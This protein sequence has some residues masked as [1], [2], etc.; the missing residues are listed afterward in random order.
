MT[1][2][3]KRGDHELAFDI[4][5]KPKAHK[6]KE[7]NMGY[8]KHTIRGVEIFTD[9]SDEELMAAAEQ[10]AKG[11]NLDDLD[12]EDIWSKH[13][14]EVRDSFVK[15]AEMQNRPETAER[16]PSETKAEHTM[17]MRASEAVRKNLVQET[18]RILFAGKLV[19]SPNEKF[20]GLVNTP[21]PKGSEVR[22]KL[23]AIEA[24]EQEV[25]DKKTEAREAEKEQRKR[26]GL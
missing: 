3:K 2:E 4:D 22:D 18:A 5:I 23:D 13:S 7:R 16:L 11:E 6:R 14:K 17:R 8:G 21:A 9:K 26:E 1:T 20:M 19:L 15:G 12:L 25:E 24:H 10:W